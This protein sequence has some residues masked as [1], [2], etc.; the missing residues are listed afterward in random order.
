MILRKF[1]FSMSV[2]H[3]GIF[4]KSKP[5]PHF[6]PSAILDICRQCFIVEFKEILFRVCSNSVSHNK[7]QFFVTRFFTMNFQ[8]MLI[9]SSWGLLVF[10]AI[11]SSFT[12]D[13]PEFLRVF[14]PV[15]SVLYLLHNFVHRCYGF[16]EASYTD[17]WF[18]WVISLVDFG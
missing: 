4:Y 17:D 10:S 6:V 5:D 3:E 8:S 2:D 15:R 18:S 7:I 13:S 1:F 9:L 11:T 12:I 14:S 16:C